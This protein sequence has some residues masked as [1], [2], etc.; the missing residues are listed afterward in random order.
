MKDYVALGEF[1]KKLA[2]CEAT[3]ENEKKKSQIE[4]LNNQ[5]VIDQ[6]KL[7]LSRQ[8][9]KT[10]S[11]QK[12]ILVG[13]ILLLLL[14]GF[15]VFRNIILNRKNEATQRQIIEKEF[16]IQKLERENTKME[17]QQKEIE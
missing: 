6:Q 3:A 14:L 9:V 1:N 17:L 5:Q 12:N 10:E 8:Q 4:L 11:F 13:S 15:I 7:Q 2:I 16:N